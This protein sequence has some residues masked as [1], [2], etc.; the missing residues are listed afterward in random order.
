METSCAVLEAN[1]QPPGRTPTA[2]C[3]KALSDHP[4]T[5]WPDSSSLSKRIL[6]RRALRR[7]QLSSVLSNVHVIF[8][9]HAEFSTDVDS[10]L[11]AECHSGTQL[12][13]VSMNEVRPLVAIH[14]N[15]MS[16]AMREVLVPWFVSCIGDYF[17]CCGI[18]RLRF[19]A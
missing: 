13:R 2:N 9:A 3:R 16:E 10:R 6:Q 4:I 18:N 19:D 7:E 15:A 11:I 12:Q 5:R 1:K 8:E 17:P 14:A